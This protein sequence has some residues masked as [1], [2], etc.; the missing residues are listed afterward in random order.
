MLVSVQEL[1]THFSTEAGLI[2]AVDGVSFDI[3]AGR[4][5]CLVGESG[6]GK[7][8]TG[9]SILRM[10]EPPGRIVGGRIMLDGRDLLAC[11]D[12]EMARLR[13]SAISL[14]PQDPSSSLNPMIRIGAQMVE[15]IRTHEPTISRRAARERARDALASVGIPSPEER[16]DA[17]PFQFSGGMRQRVVIATAF[18][19][20]PRLV[21]ADE[22]TTALDV[23]IQGQIL[24]EVQRMAKEHNTALLW[25]THDLALASELADDIAVMYGGQIVEKGETDTLLRQPRHH[26]TIGLLRS[27]PS[28]N[29]PGTLLPQIDGT[30]TWA[31]SN[32]SGCRFMARCSN[33]Q[34]DC[35]NTVDETLISN[36]HY[37]RCLHPSTAAIDSLVTKRYE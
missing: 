9:M 29:D 30:Q 15:A 2:K 33:R 37:V 19:N 25:I 27:I 3:N 14:I 36:N 5:L 28:M 35:E 10:I 4:I 21:I 22:P 34:P 13:G 23:T 1:K 26:Y 24:M 31:T 20:R 7:S 8:V 32:Q 17:Y 6:S 12:Q 16:L 18:I 11:D